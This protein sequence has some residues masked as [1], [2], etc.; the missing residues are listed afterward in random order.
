MR[1]DPP[2]R[3]V[4]GLH[5]RTLGSG[6]PL[7]VLEAGIAAT[8]ANWISVQ[9]ELS[10]RAQTCSYDR[11]GLGWSPAAPGERTLRR[12]SDD[13]HRLIHQLGETPVVLVGHSFGA[14]VVR[15]Y[16]H[17]FPNDVAALV[18]VDPMVPEEFAEP[19]LRTRLRLWRA[20][21]FSYVAGLG[22]AAG[23]VRLGLWALLRRGPGNPGP[24]LGVSATLRRVADE[25]GKL[26]PEAVAALRVHWTRPRFY[27]ELAAAI[28][29]LPSCARE[30]IGLPV[31]EHLPVTVLSGSHQ[32]PAALERHRAL[33]TRHR[34]VDGSAHWIHLDHPSLVAEA[35]LAAG[36][37]SPL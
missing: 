1:V 13:L 27:W 37:A 31:P 8:S 5:M 26:P 23:L 18:L 9:Q 36:P 15:V 19:T 35:I 7:V 21:F 4:S 29:A 6:R 25:V 16:A 32:T 12:W 34:V 22:A 14:C 24:V 20:A 2:G 17:R 33:A 28:A 30:A 10:G 11:A 3:F